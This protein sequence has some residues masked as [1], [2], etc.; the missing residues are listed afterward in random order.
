MGGST[1]WHTWSRLGKLRSEHQ[2]CEYDLR[3]GRS[4]FHLDNP[5][6]INAYRIAKKSKKRPDLGW[7]QSHCWLGKIFCRAPYTRRKITTFGQ[8]YRLKTVLKTTGSIFR[9]VIN[10]NLMTERENARFQPKISHNFGLCQCGGGWTSEKMSAS[11]RVHMGLVYF[12]L[13][14]F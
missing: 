7:F 10:L 4:T 14:T 1:A 12:D 6:V 9:S 2:L 8:K 13:S 11:M 5:V 3:A